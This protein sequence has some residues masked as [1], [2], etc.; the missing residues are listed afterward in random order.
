MPF[1]AARRLRR[2]TPCLPRHS[3]H[4][5]GNPR[6]QP[7]GLRHPRSPRN[8][9]P[10]D[11]LT[12]PLGPI[13]RHATATSRRRDSDTPQAIQSQ[14][15]PNPHRP[16]HDP[17]PNR[18]TRC[19]RNRPKFQTNVEHH[20]P[21]PRRPV[22]HHRT[23]PHR[24]HRQPRRSLFS[25]QL[26]I[27]DAQRTLH[28]LRPGIPS[29]KSP[30]RIN[31]TGSPP[32]RRRPARLRQLPAARFLHPPFR[33]N[34]IPTPHRPRRTTRAK[35]VDRAVEEQYPTNQPPFPTPEKP[36]D[37]RFPIPSFFAI[38]KAYAAKLLRNSRRRQPSPLFGGKR[39]ARTATGQPVLSLSKGRQLRRRQRCSIRDT[40][41]QTSQ[42][43]QRSSSNSFPEI[44]A[45]SFTVS[46]FFRSDRPMRYYHDIDAQRS[47]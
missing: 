13:S 33:R 20:P 9:S 12:F 10:P 4:P 6:R 5:R 38:F 22:A 37:F 14:S 21:R 35:A 26:S 32:P 1:H 11:R 46:T 19:R 44:R 43:P 29:R 8:A 28:G 47:G 30:R 17:R 42:N 36:A 2:R 3:R 27:T 16:R 34:R 18:N 40:A 41:R 45:S 15:P 25:L 39:P 31:R 24:P 7:L 23:P